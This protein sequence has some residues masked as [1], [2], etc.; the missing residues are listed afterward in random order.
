MGKDISDTDASNDTS[1]DTGDKNGNLEIDPDVVVTKETETSIG[2]SQ[3]FY[4][5]SH[6]CTVTKY[7]DSYQGHT[8]FSK[9]IHVYTVHSTKVES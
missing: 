5:E 6:A 3:C 2:S 1:E 4:A 8:E 7:L 9:F